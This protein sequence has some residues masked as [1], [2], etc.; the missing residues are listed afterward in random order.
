M[1][2]VLRILSTLAACALLPAFSVNA[3]EEAAA[4]ER[5]TI[6]WYDVEVIVFRHSDPRSDETWP[7][8]RGLPQ[9]DGL[10]PLYPPAKTEDGTEV[11]TT[12]LDSDESR[13][14]I[15]APEPFQP[16]P[17]DELQLRNSRAALDRSSRYEPLLHFAWSQPS[18]ERE[19]S[20][21]LRL[22]LPGSLDR[23]DEGMNGDDG[24][25]FDENNE[26]TDTYGDQFTFEN[27]RQ[28]SGSETMGN[29]AFDVNSAP[30]FARPLDGYVQLGVGQ[31]LHVALDLLYLP[32]D[33]NPDVVE[34]A[35]PARDDLLTTKQ[36][37]REARHRAVMEALARG[38][39]GMEEAD[40][41][42]LE[43]EEQ[44]FHGF[45]LNDVRRVRSGELHYF[46]H[47]VYGVL[48]TVRPR[49]VEVA[50]ADIEQR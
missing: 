25:W 31:Y 34:G 48:V 16:L 21:M 4:E 19:N 49:Q 17:E 7:L 28:D 15:D 33:I 50:S 23:P 5:E 2:R 43:P 41:L 29:D 44:V 32:E 26:K 18:L 47:P 1:H 24:A 6:K 10:Q 3:A 37:E 30:A 42:M 11:E 14:L 27:A 45:R 22:T 39:I 35:L 38:D 9:V 13:M 8:D 20:P 36:S 12:P 46:D 40:I